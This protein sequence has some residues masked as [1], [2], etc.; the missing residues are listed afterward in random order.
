MDETKP[1]DQK[2]SLEPPK[3]I[4]G[5]LKDL[6]K[7]NPPPPPPLTPPR[8][9]GQS[10]TLSVPHPLSGANE[11][12]SVSP[13]PLTPPASQ[14]SPPLLK[15]PTDA[16]A[17]AGRPEGTAKPPVPS[18]PSTQ[19][20]QQDKFKSLI[21]T[22]GEDLELAK[23]GAKPESRPFEIKPPPNIPKVTPIQPPKPLTPPSL[24]VKLGPAERTRSLELPKPKAPFIDISRAKKSYFLKILIPILGIVIV[25]AGVWYFMLRNNEIADTTPTIT[26]TPRPTPISKTLSELIPLSSQITISSA[27]NFLTALNNGIKSATLT[28]GGWLA[29]NLV[30]Q[31]E[32]KYSLNQIFQKLNITLPNGILENL[33]S[34]NWTLAVYGQKEMYDS[35]GL[36]S[37]NLTPKPK[38]GLIAKTNFPSSLRSAL[39]NWEITM[40]D[41]FKNVLGLDPQKA[42]TQTFLD[43]IYYGAEI[44]YRNFSYADNSIDYTILNLSEFGSNYLILTNSRESIYSAI[45]LLQNQ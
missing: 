24:E 25:F 32:V 19:V 41:G 18:S 21:R 34:T 38:L 10:G 44:R 15:A 5:L 28:N 39:N 20:N 13:K 30:D 9:A 40:T 7:I 4:E 37:F 8:S 23:K 17:V 2:P 26:P 11:T 31:N 1:T 35:K 3:D 33:D 14:N 43:N 16:K 29:L 42:P 45:D 22:M 6:P 36:L 27:E 12:L